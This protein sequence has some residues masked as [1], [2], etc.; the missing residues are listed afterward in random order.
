MRRLATIVGL[1]LLAALLGCL[2]G[3]GGQSR[4]AADRETGAAT[5]NPW[6]GGYKGTYTGSYRG[7]W[8]MQVLSDGRA[9]LAGTLPNGGTHVTSGTVTATGSFKMTPDGSSALVKGQFTIQQG[10]RTFSGTWR[11]PDGKSGTLSGAEGWIVP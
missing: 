1:V 6:A 4:A 3:C 7:T 10:K 2:C 5:S 8:A 9:R 11:D